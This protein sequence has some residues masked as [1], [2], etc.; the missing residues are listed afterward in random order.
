[1]KPDFLAANKSVQCDGYI[2]TKS[3]SFECEVDLITGLGMA[4]CFLIVYQLALDK[5]ISHLRN[6]SISRCPA[7]M[8]VLQSS[9]GFT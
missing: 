9:T 7:C 8:P 6:I 4:H 5:I 1:M 2:Y 3:Y